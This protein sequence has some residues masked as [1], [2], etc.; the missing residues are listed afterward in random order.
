M[1][2]WLNRKR[3]K[4][5][6]FFRHS[7]LARALRAIANVFGPRIQASFFKWHAAGRAFSI[8]FSLAAF[9]E[10]FFLERGPVHRQ[11]SG[12]EP[13]ANDQIAVLEDLG[14]HA[15]FAVVLQLATEQLV[16]RPYF[17]QLLVRVSSGERDE[18]GRR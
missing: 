1:A 12:I 14:L 5:A 3:L 2:N 8:H 6:S 10:V 4:F 9:L 7:V 17:P 16:A 15:K 13:P 18:T 11:L